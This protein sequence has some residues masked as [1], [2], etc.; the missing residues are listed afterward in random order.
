ME[1]MNEEWNEEEGRKGVRGD[2]NSKL[3]EVNG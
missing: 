3:L 2:I 1:G